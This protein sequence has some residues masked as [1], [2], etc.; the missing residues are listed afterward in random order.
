MKN[1][2]IYSF[3]TGIASGAL[4]LVIF[5]TGVH[6]LHPHTATAATTGRTFQGGAA[7]TAR[8]AQRLGITEAE[9]QKELDS[10]KT[11]QQI[12]AEHGVTFGGGRRGGSGSTLTGSG[13]GRTGIPRSS[14]STLPLQ[15]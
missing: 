13:A 2:H 5:S 7:N 6:I 9:L 10:G 11:M 12:A 1:L 8:M 3:V 4:L 14:G 15:Q